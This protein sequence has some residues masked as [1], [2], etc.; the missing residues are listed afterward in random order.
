M[1]PANALLRCQTNTET[2]TSV[3]HQVLRRQ[4]LAAEQT[5]GLADGIKEARVD[6]AGLSRSLSDELTSAMREIE[7]QVRCDS[8][9]IFMTRRCGREV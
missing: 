4:E 3:S 8:F 7:K 2:C 1:F 9:Y 5:A 6:L